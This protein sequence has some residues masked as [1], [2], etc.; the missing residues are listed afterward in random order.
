MGADSHRKA[1]LL[2]KGRDSALCPLYMVH[3]QK[4][5]VD[6]QKIPMA[7]AEHQEGLEACSI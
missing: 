5:C 1:L 6:C 3:T 2:V 4:K 7:G